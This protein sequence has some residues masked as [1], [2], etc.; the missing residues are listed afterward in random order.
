M[1]ISLMPNIY[2]YIFLN[3]VPLWD[4]SIYNCHVS[5][6]NDHQCDAL[7]P[8]TALP[9]MFHYFFPPFWCI[10]RNLPWGVSLIFHAINCQ[11][12][13]NMTK[14]KKEY[15]EWG[16][17]WTLWQ[18][19]ELSEGTWSHELHHTAIYLWKNPTHGISKGS[20]LYVSFNI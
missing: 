15:I 2:S 20:F 6:N 12:F 3:V 10:T 9:G 14:W 1:L 4:F 16:Y 19:T 8:L 17:C 18:R 13:T 7:K 5:C 11:K